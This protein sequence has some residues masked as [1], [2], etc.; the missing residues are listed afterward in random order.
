MNV[1][2]PVCGCYGD[3]QHTVELK[4]TQ[5]NPFRVVYCILILDYYISL[6]CLALLL[7][8]LLKA[9]EDLGLLY[10][11]RVVNIFGIVLMLFYYYC[12]YFTIVSVKLNFKP[13][14]HVNTAMSR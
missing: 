8:F 14:I 9:D 11:R 12:Y 13:C 3:E 6:Y 1:A 10:I 4:F 2:C 7:L 5:Q